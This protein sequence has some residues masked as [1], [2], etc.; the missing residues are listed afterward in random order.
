MLRSLSFVL[1][2][3]VVASG[4]ISAPA[5]AKEK[6][7]KS[8]FKGCPAGLTFAPDLLKKISWA[9]GIWSFPGIGYRPPKEWK[10]KS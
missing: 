9:R 5:D 6:E 7:K 10:C 2:A 8:H 4:A 3:A 1:L